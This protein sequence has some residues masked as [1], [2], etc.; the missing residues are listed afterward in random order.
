MRDDGLPGAWFAWFVL[1]AVLVV[2]ALV[3]WGLGG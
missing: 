1:W 2:V 3:A